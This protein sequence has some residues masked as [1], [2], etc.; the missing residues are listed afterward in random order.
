MNLPENS[1]QRVQAILASGIKIPPIPVILLRLNE[2]LRDPDTDAAALAALISHD[3]ALS[4][5]VFRVIGSPVFGLR[6][7]VDSLPHAISLLGLQTIGALLRSEILVASLSDPQHAR[8]LETLWQRS[9]AIAELCLRTVKTARLRDINA[10]AAYMIGMF[11]DCGLALLC[12]RFPIYAQALGTEDGW[13]DIPALDQ[14]QNLSHAV[15]GQMV[16]KNWALPEILVQAIRHH[17]DP[18]D[19]DARTDAITDTQRLCGVLNLAIHLY[20]LQH[21]IDDPDWAARWRVDTMQRLG[22]D[23]DQLDEWQADILSDAA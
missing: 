5:A 18:I 16:A 23:A 22:A 14:S 8:A 21:E 17:H 6:S 15:M 11:H 13:P 10:E 20:N 19:P 12:K 1:D 2:L 3:G 7:K 4:G 9:A